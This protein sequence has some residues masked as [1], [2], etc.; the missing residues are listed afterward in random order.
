MRIALGLG[1]GP[2]VDLRLKERLARME[3]VLDIVLS[4]IH[5]GRGR[6]GGGDSGVTVS[7]SFSLSNAFKRIGETSSG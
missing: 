3:D 1:P 2:M 6:G 7:I 5:G 4:R